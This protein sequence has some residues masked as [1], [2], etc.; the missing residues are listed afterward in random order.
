ML[1]V[2]M[3]SV[4]HEPKSLL[5][6]LATRPSLNALLQ[7]Y[8]WVAL[9]GILMFGAMF[10]FTGVDWDEEQHLHPDERFL[11]MVSTA[12]RLPDSVAQYFDTETS[13]MNPY[14]NN[15]GSF[16]YGTAPL[17]IVRIAAQLVDKAEYW[18]IY[19]VGRVL[20][21]LF[22]LFTC[23]M[24][25][26]IGRR[27]FDVRVGLMAAL[28]YA[29]AVLPI[30][31]AHFFTVD[32]FG[33]VPIVLAFWFTLDIMEGKRGW[34]AYGLAG[35]ALGLAVA[36]RINFVTFA[37]IIVLAAILRLV[38]M[39]GPVKRIGLAANKTRT[40][41][42]D[43]GAIVPSSDV[44]PSNVDASGVNLHTRTITLGPII[45]EI[46]T[47]PRA[48]VGEQE[49]GVRETTG[50]WN[51]VLWV[52]AGLVICAFA[53][54]V[55]F[56]VGQPYAFT[57]L[58][59]I[60]PKWLDDMK[61]ISQLISGDIDYP[62]S[63]QWTGRAAYLFPLYN[64]F[65]YGF[66]IPFAF[67]AWA[68]FLVG[69]YEILRYRKWNHLLIVLWIGGFFLYQ[70]Q[71]FVL[72]IRYYL[73]LYPFLAIY[74]AFFVLWLWDHA[75]QAPLPWLTLARVARAAVVV[76]VV[77]YTIFWASAFTTIYMRPVTRVAASKWIVH[78]VPQGSVIA[79]E[80]WDDPLPMRVEGLDPFGGMFKGLSTSSDGMIQNYW[81][82]SEEK[83]G[84][85]QK[86]LDEADYIVM[87]SNRLYASIPRLPRRYPMTTKYYEWL[88]NGE[89]GF[90]K[91]KE[92]TSYPQLFGIVINDDSS[93]EAFTV[94][95]HPKVLIYKKSANYSSEHVAQLLNSVDL[96]EFEKLKPIEAV[97]SKNG[98]RMSPELQAAN[99][100]G[101]T[102]S[103]IFHPDDL[104]N[105]VPVVA[106]LIAIW[107]IGVLAFP[108]TFV[109]FRKFADRG[110]AFAKTIGVLAFAW[111]TW[112]LASYGALPFERTT[113]FLM[114][115]TMLLG[116]LFVIWRKGLEML[117]YLRAHWKLLV[118]IE[119]VYLAFFALDLAIRFGNPDLWHPY[120]GGEK[121]M[122]F[123]YLNAV[124]KTTYFPAY[125][126]WFAGGFINYYY[127]GQLISATL[128]KFTGIVPEVAYN[129][130]LP[131]FFGLTASGAFGVA[132]NVLAR[133]TEDGGQGA[134]VGGRGSD[135]RQATDDGRRMTTNLRPAL[136][137]LAAAALVLVIGNLGQVGVLF[138]GLT[139][140]GR[141]VGANDGI[142]AFVMGVLAW[143]GGKEIPV[144]IG[145]WYWTATRIIPET[146]NE[147]PFFTFVYAD[148]HA[149]LMSLP[150]TLAGLGLAAHAVINRARL[151]WYDLGI[152]A[153]VLGALRAINTWDYPTY[154]A[155]IGCA[156]VVGYFADKHQTTDESPFDWSEFIQ[157]YLL[158][159][160]LVFVQIAVTVIPINAAGFKITFDMG[161]YILVVLFALALGFGK[162]GLQLDPRRIA[163]DLGLRMIALIALGVLFYWPY[164]ANYGTAY[165]SVELWS[166]ARTLLSDYLVVH[167]IFLFLAGTYLVV[168]LA[169]KSARTMIT[170]DADTEAQSLM[171][172]WTIYLLPALAVLVVGLLILGLQVFAVVVPLAAAALWI[173]FQHD[174][175]PIHRF[176]SLVIVAALLLTLMV[177]VVTLKGD[178]GRM[179]TVFKFYLQAWVFFAVASASGLAIVFN[180]L[181]F[182]Q[183]RVEEV[184]AAT[185][186]SLEKIGG[187]SPVMQTVKAAW[188]GLAALLIVAGML[189]PVFAGWA[190]VNDRFVQGMPP[191]LNGL[192]YMKQASYSENNIEFP[193]EPDYQAIQWLRQNIVG[194]PVIVEGNTGL[195]HWG[196]RISINTGLPV[197][198]GWD[199]HT[200][201]QY[202]LLPGEE[203]DNRIQD[204]RTIYETTDPA[205]A[206]KWLHEFG[207][208]LIYVGPLEHALYF[209]EGFAKFDEM[210]RDGILEKIYDK[211]SVQIYALREKAAQVVK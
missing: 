7:Q 94:Y 31:E 37:A 156:M 203:I 210:T 51:A 186:T 14:N 161:I 38:T 8:W 71:Q 173:L 104:V 165:T 89:L 131:M 135:E 39:L 144:P 1:D 162:F 30:Q 5:N 20:S 196:D 113:M 180:H 61:F 138:Q 18:N 201:Q 148:L 125:N 19:L 206:L 176:L 48:A 184:S 139:E 98:F 29:C 79:N 195:Y 40:F 77:G 66:G 185:G 52:G 159:I 96:T 134:G 50:F 198:V 28:L 10:R 204:I 65:N 49:A 114:L 60:N 12:I 11:T 101:G 47:K 192:D 167:G 35:A 63:H 78:N 154:L 118:G 110:Y 17:F 207:V 34:L 69:I 24:V 133:A 102:W 152:A 95:D 164:I 187:D 93:D 136:A 151:R 160:V 90:E 166:D 62:P 172:G 199:W 41:G 70:A 155:L 42:M 174:T 92:F 111:L 16:V 26:A 163:W 141:Q 45:L 57:G 175:A 91:V 193:L 83:R 147:M 27:L 43:A 84:D 191:G 194:S 81:E 169:R 44:T 73:P 85:M 181:W 46:E 197:V 143:I 105:A 178:I 74:A 75:R 150:F 145:N 53:A 108:F 13:P 87:S 205:E 4:E 33:N 170:P 157:R 22:D 127:F 32:A 23:A 140:L 168:L 112:T 55:V 80:H 130:L 188:W 132:Y 182:R 9:I 88:F 128:V 25:F 103:D 21:A 202:S 15:F 153:M 208:S 124:I 76:V 209:D 86:W 56:R 126:P 146:I 179:N 183:A 121:P 117:A 177:E 190:K 68:G 97:A 116:A 3:D 142:G 67:A 72:V 149:H 82:D 123:A 107:L 99:Y 59:G 189:Y 158:F 58:I 211:D 129:L 137:G 122:D 115:G 64:M 119:I 54:L 171:E 200:K 6:R 36:S 2:S 120:F 106:W 100:A 109:A